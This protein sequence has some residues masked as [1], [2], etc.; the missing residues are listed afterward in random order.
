MTLGRPADVE[1]L[2]AIHEGAEEYN[3][4]YKPDLEKRKAHHREQE[5]LRQKAEMDKVKADIFSGQGETEV[6]VKGAGD[7]DGDDSD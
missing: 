3:E 1:A 5:V 4:F 2:Q 6:I 7:A